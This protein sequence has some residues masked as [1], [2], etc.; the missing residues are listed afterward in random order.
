M[1]S[2]VLRILDANYNRVGEGLRVLEEYA[3]LG[4]ND[5]ALTSRLKILRHAVMATRR[6]FGDEALL[7]ARDIQGDVGT[8]IGTQSERTRADAGH[9][10]VAAAKR[11]GESLR[12]VEE[13]GKVLSG[14]IAANIEHL[15]YE[16]YAI[17]QDLRIA[18]PGRARL[19]PG[20]LHVLVTEELCRGPWLET[21]RQALVGGADVLQLREKSCGDREL[22]A[23]TR[24]LRALTAEHGAM[25]F[26]N[27]RPDVA[28]LAQ[29]DGVHV[30]RS[31]LP[32]EE[33]RR[34]GGA[35]LLVGTSTHDVGEVRAALAE[36]ADYIA[37]G[38]MFASATKPAIG[39]RGPSLLREVVGDTDAPVVAIG[40][41]TA[42]NVPRLSAPRPI[43]VA[44]C[45]AILASVDPATATAE[46]KR[47]LTVL[48]SA[49][50]D[51]REN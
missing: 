5:A 45:Q 19:K 22:L 35:R 23:R 3:R 51:N 14:D 41:I 12:C 9:V 48:N 10:V 30:G 18:G 39:V 44:V 42:S 46:L 25:L 40:G 21:C 15:R 49:A 32:V 8:Q 28:A 24:K 36:R 6:A 38:P 4:L 2:A 47:A 13:Y 29:A 16:F 27:D 33:A 7:A 11:V 20:L 1:D 31:D 34:I 17:E 37:V 26:V 43:H 50:S